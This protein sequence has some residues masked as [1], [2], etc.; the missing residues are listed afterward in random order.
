VPI[1]IAVPVSSRG[2]R[3]DEQEVL[4]E[5]EALLLRFRD[6]EGGLRETEARPGLRLS[7]LEIR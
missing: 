6:E 3:A 1:W 5:L 7:P 4:N 2:D